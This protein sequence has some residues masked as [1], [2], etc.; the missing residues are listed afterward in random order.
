MGV[1]PTYTKQMLVQNTPEG[2]ARIR[3][4][5]QVANVSIAETMRAAT[6]LGLPL[7]AEAYGISMET[8][9]QAQNKLFPDVEPSAG[10]LKL[11]NAKR[12]PR[13]RRARA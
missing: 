12:G 5:A 8:V 1:K 13:G 11:G 9:T 4:F 3:A 7:L 10:G 6:E 2:D